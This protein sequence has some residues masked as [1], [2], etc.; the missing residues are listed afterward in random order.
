MSFIKMFDFAYQAM[1]NETIYYYDNGPLTPPTGFFTNLSTRH[2][3]NRCSRCD[4]SVN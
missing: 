4:Q 2:C 1:V 3:K